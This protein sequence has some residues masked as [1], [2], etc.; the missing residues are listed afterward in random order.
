MYLSIN[1]K[2]YI[3]LDVV[4]ILLR[5]FNKTLTAFSFFG[6]KAEVSAA[7]LRWAQLSGKFINIQVNCYV[8][9]LP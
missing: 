9:Y 7:L 3:F 4:L 6:V 5:G 8:R 1:I 2:K